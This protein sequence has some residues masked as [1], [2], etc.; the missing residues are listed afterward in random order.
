MRPTSVCLF[1]LGGPN[2]LLGVPKVLE[3]TNFLAVYW[4]AAGGQFGGSLIFMVA[5]FAIFYFLLI[6]P[7]Q[8]RQKKWQQMLG[9][10]KAGDKVVTTG[11]IRGVIFSVKDDAL[12]LRVAPDNIKLEVTRQAIASVITEENPKS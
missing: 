8:R 6:M 2:S 11:G 10:L 9:E 4:Q 7:Q 3:M 1:Y 12:V 5:I